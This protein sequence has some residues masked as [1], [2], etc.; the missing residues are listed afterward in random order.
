M[1]QRFPRLT[2][3]QREQMVSPLHGLT[4]NSPGG[5]TLQSLQE[6]VER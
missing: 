4:G 5:L 6:S 1:T 3:R 2:F